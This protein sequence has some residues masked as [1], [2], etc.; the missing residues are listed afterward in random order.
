MWAGQL[1]MV[2]IGVELTRRAALDH[3]PSLL[4]QIGEMFYL[5]HQ[6]IQHWLAER[7]GKS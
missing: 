2:A 4:M 7:M 6:R 5:I 3:L 1:G